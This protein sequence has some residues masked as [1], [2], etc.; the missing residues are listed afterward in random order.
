MKSIHLV[1]AV[2]ALTVLAAAAQAQDVTTVIRAAKVIDGRGQTIANG[3]IVVTGSRITRVG[4]RGA[5]PT[6]ARVI[7]LGNRTVM[8]GLIDGHS[9]LTWYFNR[10]GRYHTARDGDTPIQSM[11]AAAANGAATLM[12]G[13]TTIQSPGS[14]E[15]KDLRDWIETQGLPG[16]RI[17]TS[18]NALQRG[19]PDTLRMLVRQRKE[20]GADMIKLFASASIRDGGAQTLTDEQIA[21]VCGEAQAQGMRTMI[22]AHSKESVK[23]SA[24]GGC[25]EVTH[26][27]FVDQEALDLMAAKG[28]YFQPQCSLVFSNYLDNRAKYDGIGNYNAEG[29]AAMERALPLAADAI[30]R[31]LATKGLKITYGTDA[32]AGA[33]GRNAEDMVCRVQKSGETPMHVIV[34]ATSV[35][36]EALGLGSRIGSLASGYEADIIAVDGD[37]LA[38]ITNMRRVSFVMKGGRVYRNDG[39]R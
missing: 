10:Q 14:P 39:N 2:S 24:N 27:V 29:F 26:G 30:K 1:L 21:A 7:D 23:A 11:L 17:I 5:V 36:A 25:W 28:T 18:L 20:L 37:P 3:D 33:H 19:S 22:H 6:G 32:V 15:D 13:F 12:A 9:H 4:A 38:D 35:N 16:P 34:A 31:A 8:P